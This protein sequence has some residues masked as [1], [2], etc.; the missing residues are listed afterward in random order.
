MR[1]LLATTG[2]GLMDLITVLLGMMHGVV[3]IT[4]ETSNVDFIF[5][6]LQYYPRS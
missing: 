5:N 3:V 1:S 4:I 6:V 2:E